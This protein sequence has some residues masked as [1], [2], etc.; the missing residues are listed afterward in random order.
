[1]ERKGLSSKNDQTGSART[2]S[3]PE[4]QPL[5]TEWAVYADPPPVLTP[6][7]VIALQHTIGNQAVQRLLASREQDADQ[8][9][10]ATRI[11][12]QTDAGVPGGSPRD[13]S[14]PAGVPGHAPT[15]QPVSTVPMWDD[16]PRIIR[17]LSPNS[18][19]Y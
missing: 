11:A 3:N 15:P 12:R 13:A 14:L 9:G 2:P 16:L 19:T 17:S 5:I 7:N 6:A 8:E 10:V 18:R 1:M 4:K